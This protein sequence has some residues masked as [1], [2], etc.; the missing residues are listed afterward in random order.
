M[1]EKTAEAGETPDEGRDRYQAERH[2][3][4]GR[5]A[6][7]GQLEGGRSKSLRAGT[8]Q[9]NIPGPLVEKPHEPQGECHP[10]FP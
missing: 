4:T 2:D 10:D 8:A 6:L 1:S 7:P 3:R 5:V 9:G